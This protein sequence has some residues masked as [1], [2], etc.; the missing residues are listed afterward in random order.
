MGDIWQDQA[1]RSQKV[2]R[3]YVKRAT[4]G[5]KSKCTKCTNGMVPGENGGNMKCEC[6]R[7]KLD[8]KL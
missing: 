1:K 5:R 3:S 7:S 4:R 6:T 8:I 2:I